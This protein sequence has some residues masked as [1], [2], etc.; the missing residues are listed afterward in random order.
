MSIKIL[1]SGAFDP[2][3]I[4]H[5]LLLKE[6]SEYGDV[7]VA[8]NSDEWIIKKKGYILTPFEIRQ[9][10]VN[11]VPYVSETIGF[12]D[13]DGT[14]CSALETV[15]PDFFGNGGG[16]SAFNTP[17]KEVELCDKMGIM[18]VW[19]LG[20]SLKDNKYLLLTLD[21]VLKKTLEEVSNLNQFMEKIKDLQD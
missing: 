12:D 2:L 19:N 15:K 13:I 1:I 18:P 3:H 9:E 7:V 16:R 14:A 20:E 21:N 4:G 11:S 8:L 5:I 17:K 6:A 10:L